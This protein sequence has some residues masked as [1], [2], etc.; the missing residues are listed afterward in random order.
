MDLE[1]EKKQERKKPVLGL[2]GRSAFGS[3]ISVSTVKRCQGPASVLFS[4]PSGLP[5]PQPSEVRLG[6]IPA[7]RGKEPV[8]EITA[9]EGMSQFI[10]PKVSKVFLPLLSRERRIK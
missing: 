5:L 9:V 3:K 4:L 2:V 10:Y 7:G 6:A 8:G 1:Y